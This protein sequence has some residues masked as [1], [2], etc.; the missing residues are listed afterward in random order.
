MTFINYESFGNPPS[1]QKKRVTVHVPS[2]EW[3]VGKGLCYHALMDSPDHL[4][5]LAFKC[6]ISKGWAETA[7]GYKEMVD[8]GLCPNR[9]SGISQSI[10]CAVALLTTP[11]HQS[12][13]QRSVV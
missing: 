10:V 12:R 6:L 8:W 13:L 7:W 9:K 3:S 11:P 2:L 5:E 4:N 1:R